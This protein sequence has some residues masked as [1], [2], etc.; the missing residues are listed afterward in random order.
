MDQEGLK[1]WLPA[2]PEVLSGYQVLLDAVQRQGLE[3]QCRP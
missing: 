1:R 2:D 3:P